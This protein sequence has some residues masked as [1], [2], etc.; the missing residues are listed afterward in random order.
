MSP[1]SSYAPAKS[2]R[3][4]SATLDGADRPVRYVGKKENQKCA[5]P[6]SSQALGTSTMSVRFPPS[7]TQYGRSAPRW[8][9]SEVM[10]CSASS[11]KVEGDSAQDGE[12]YPTGALPVTLTSASMPRSTITR[13]SSCVSE[14]G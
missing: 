5:E 3:Q 4:I 13:S 9:A 10:P 11:E 2:S 7:T 14:V 1:L 12:R 8:L 6:H